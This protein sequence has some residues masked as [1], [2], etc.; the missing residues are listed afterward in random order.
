MTNERF[1]RPSCAKV[2]ASLVT[3]GIDAA[4]GCVLQQDA[5]SRT[6]SL[7]PTAAA[8]AVP[9]GRNAAPDPVSADEQFKETDIVLGI[10]GFQQQSDQKHRLLGEPKLPGIARR[11]TAIAPQPQPLLP[12]LRRCCRRAS[13]AHGFTHENLWTEATTMSHLV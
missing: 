2:V 10:D 11:W 12:P 4:L 13:V 5:A 6:C 8:T 9:F 1:D 7:Y 3:R